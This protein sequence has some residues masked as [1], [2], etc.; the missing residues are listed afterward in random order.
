MTAGATGR[1]SRPFGHE[2]EI[3]LPDDFHIHLR[4]GLQLTMYSRDA[5]ASFG[6]VMVAP[7]TVPPVRIPRQ[8]EKYRER[9]LQSV[10]GAAGFEPLMSFCVDEAMG[11][12]DIRGFKEA[13]AVAGVFYPTGNSSIEAVFHVLEAMQAHGIVLSIHAENDAAFVLDREDSFLADVERIVGRF[14]DLRM[15]I[16]HISSAT[17]LNAL[18]GLPETVAA[19]VT[20][21]HLLYT[22]DDIIAD[23]IRPHRFCK[24]LPRRKED[25]DALR[26]A[27]FSGNSRLFFASDSV[28][29]SPPAPDS[30]EMAPGVYGAPTAI[31]LLLSLF[32]ECAGLDAFA[33][34]TARNGA[35]F[36]GL[37]PPALRCRYRREPWRIPERISDVIPLGAGERAEWKAVGRST[38]EEEGE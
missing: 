7:D 15:V 38:G 1:T 22:L 31:S 8:V 33:A 10:R 14:P 16:E 29:L 18:M 3:P 2:I 35:G 27:V 19:T 25:R 21:H 20:A 36:Y 26:E 11:D 13:G 24:P 37:A 17:T 23:V 4:Q 5:A 6:R 34:F 28:P 32:E 12:A 9:I 30:L